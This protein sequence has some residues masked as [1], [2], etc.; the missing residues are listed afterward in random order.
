VA[1]TTKTTAIS[2]RP[3][4]RPHAPA[5]TTVPQTRVDPLMDAMVEDDEIR[6]LEAG[7][8]MFGAGLVA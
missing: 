2:I 7:N 3:P 4:N 1:K 5:R 6:D 8:F